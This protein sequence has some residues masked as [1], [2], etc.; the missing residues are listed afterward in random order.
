MRENIAKSSATS[1]GLICVLNNSGYSL[2]LDNVSGLSNS[3]GKSFINKLKKTVLR[4]SPSSRP[5]VV[6][7]V[8][9]T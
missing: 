3:T 9:E 2:S 7:T 1:K 5:I 8:V 4:T 6:L